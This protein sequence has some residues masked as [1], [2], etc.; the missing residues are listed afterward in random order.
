MATAPHRPSAR[1]IDYPTGD[2]KPMAETEFHRDDMMD[3][4]QTLQ[5]F[6]AADPMVCVSGN[7][8][9]FYEEGNRR[10]HISPDVF[11][12]R[13]IE[14]KTRDNYLIW[15]EGKAPDVV[16]ELTSK[17]TRRED[18]IKKWHLYRDLMEVL[19]YFLFDPTQDYLKPPLQGFRLV[20]KEYVPI[21]P[22]GIRL[23]SEILGLHLEP[24]GRELRLFDPVQRSLLLK[25]IEKN[26][27]ANH[28][29]EIERARAENQRQR[30]D[31]E[32]AARQQLAAENERLL[33]ELE[34]LRR[35]TESPQ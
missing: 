15:E 3:L 2:G 29:A 25:R 13:G 12:V 23:P 24:V 1:K 5:D 19:E 16:I 32:A 26:E 10:K 11:V 31:A 33:Q 34:A 35:R 17:T 6:F 30:A 9:M 22:V 4:I 14:K 18:Q 8:L 20:E 21:E 27:A 7:L 28:R